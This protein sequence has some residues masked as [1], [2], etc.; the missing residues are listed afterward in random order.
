MISFQ[1]FETLNGKGRNKYN[2]TNDSH[3]Q[4]WQLN[5]ILENIEST[6]AYQS[7]FIRILQAGDL[8]SF[9]LKSVTKF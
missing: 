3:S 2:P 1:S 8:N 6:P 5:P 4:T 9:S 7:C